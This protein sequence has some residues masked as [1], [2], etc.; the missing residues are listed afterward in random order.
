MG[1]PYRFDPLGTLGAR[2]DYVKDG[3]V[4]WVDAL[5]EPDGEHGTITNFATGDVLPLDGTI[6]RSEKGLH[7][8]GSKAGCNPLKRNE[9]LC[10]ELIARDVNNVEMSSSTVSI[11]PWDGSKIVRFI[12]NG[13]SDSSMF[14][15]Y[16]SSSFICP[17]RKGKIMGYYINT[18][19][20]KAY[21]GNTVPGPASGAA[22]SND[23]SIGK[24]GVLLHSLRYYN[25]PLTEEEQLHNWKIDKLRFGE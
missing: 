15:W 17:E 7:G 23:L 6:I 24:E 19:V 18:N 22:Q 25:R 10:I 16:D 12:A 13:S 3:L 9:N 21:E 5:L 11:R 2:Q 14:R 20:W 4:L 1:I 8:V